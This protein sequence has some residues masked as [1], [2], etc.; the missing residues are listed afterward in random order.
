MY[1]AVNIV[2]KT[3]QSRLTQDLRIVSSGIYRLKDVFYALQVMSGI[4]I[5]LP[6][7]EGDILCVQF[8]SLS[9]RFAE[10]I[11]LQI[12]QDTCQR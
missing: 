5:F 12:Q 10:V 9:K 11:S 3:G 2:L 1:F 7:F 6:R 8:A 4:Y